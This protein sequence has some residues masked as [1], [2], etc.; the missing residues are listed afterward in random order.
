[1]IL[2]TKHIPPDRSLI[3]VGAEVLTLLT[4]PMTVSRL[5]DELRARRVAASQAVV[6]YKWFVLTLDL[7]FIIGAVRLDQRLLRRAAG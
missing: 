7:L 5:W 6:D 4:Q 1:M 3:G 2:P